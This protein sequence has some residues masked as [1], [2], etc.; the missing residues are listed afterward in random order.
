MV[1]H[2]ALLLVFIFTIILVSSCFTSTVNSTSDFV[3]ENPN[4][5]V[6][7]EAELRE[8]IN[9]APTK[10]SVI[11]A[12][13][14]DITLTDTTLTIPANK[15]IILTNNKATNHYKLIGT[16]HETAR[17]T[18][19]EQSV[20]TIT[21]NNEGILEL[22]G[23]DVT[24]TCNYWGY[25]VTVNEKGQFIMH[26]SLIS[27]NIGGIYNDGIFLMRDGEISGNSAMNGGGVH[28]RG[29]FTMFGGK[30]SANSAGNNGG[31]VYN[32][33][34]FEMLGG[35]ISA[36][37]GAEGGGIYNWGGAATIKYKFATNTKEFMGYDNQFGGGFILSD[38]V[39]SGNKAWRGGGVCNQGVFIMS[40]GLISDNTATASGGG[41]NNGKT[42]TM[43]NFEMSGGEISANT[44]E[45]GGGVYNFFHSTISLSDR[46]VILGNTA[47][48]GGGVCIDG[49]FNM[50]GGV[51]SGN[52]ATNNGGGV[53]LG[54]GIF[55]LTGG[56]ISKNT[57]THDG[58]GIWVDI[59]RLDLL[60]ISNGAVFL[61][62][63]ASG[64]YDRNT[65]HNQRYYA[66][67]GNTVTWTTPFTQG[68][69]NYDI[70]YTSDKQVTITNE[71]SP[72]TDNEKNNSDTEATNIPSHST[73]LIV[74][75]G[76]I[77]AII[78]VACIFVFK[79]KNRQKL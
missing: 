52:T 74:L 56:E 78:V 64:A 20:S 21:V 22:A 10:K 75:A 57:A 40:G 9:N 53:Y 12:L 23:I 28:N 66:Q 44:A 35:E 47:E 49:D 3:S 45:K 77:L 72:T 32:E 29:T 41:V 8:A 18:V 71:G 24:H 70:S 51:I 36:N 30:I 16:V 27:S 4:K 13:N 61:S 50:E 67:I 43:G 37:T 62:N 38:G 19:G 60:F 25:A 68:Y 2:I 65:A 73:I 58:G 5:I 6:S 76:I 79:N 7:N 48:L 15:N 59:E 69:N 11:I 54:N 33:G 46:G 63:R 17:F 14:N 34:T 26:K 42:S 1:K 55:K 31:G 39:I